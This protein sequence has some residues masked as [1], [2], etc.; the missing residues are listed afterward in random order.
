MYSNKMV[1]ALF[2]DEMELAIEIDKVG[3][4]RFMISELTIYSS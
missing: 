4:N 2:L 1:H 3:I